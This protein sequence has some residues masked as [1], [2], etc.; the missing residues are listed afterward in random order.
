MRSPSKRMSKTKHLS[1]V[2]SERS[3]TVVEQMPVVFGAKVL[4]LWKLGR[5]SPFQI[6]G[7]G[8]GLP[9]PRQ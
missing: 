2:S 3:T 7:L 4:R 9:R 6:L 5:D 8:T 1:L